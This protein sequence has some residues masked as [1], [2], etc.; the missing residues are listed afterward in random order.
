[1]ESFLFWLMVTIVCTVALVVSKKREAK[2]A[3]ITPGNY[4]LKSQVSNPFRDEYDYA[5]VHEVK[6]GW[7][8]YSYTMKPGGTM[9]SETVRYFS[10]LYTHYPFSEE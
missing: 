3:A 4:I 8:L 9:Y 10:N 6:D 5:K 2:D 7:V 1:M